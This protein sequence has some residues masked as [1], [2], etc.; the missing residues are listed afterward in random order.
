MPTRPRPLDVLFE[1]DAPQTFTDLTATL[2]PLPPA[3][4]HDVWFDEVHEQHSR[5]SVELAREVGEVVRKLQDKEQQHKHATKMDVSRIQDP[6]RNKENVGRSNR[7]RGANSVVHVKRLKPTPNRGLQIKRAN[8][9]PPSVQKDVPPASRASVALDRRRK[10]L[11][12]ARSRLNAGNQRTEPSERKEMR[13]LQE[14][15]KRHNKKFKASHT[16]EPPRHSV[17]DVKQKSGSRRT[18]RLRCGSS[19]KMR[20]DARTRTRVDVFEG[21]FIL[22]LRGGGGGCAS[23]RNWRLES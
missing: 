3:E 16:Y 22:P 5:P 17:R 8:H 10:P 13:D 18:R 20:R 23:R 9:K 4:T 6:D 15:L 19:N 1:F 11:V 14:L 12:D 21:I 7:R 2:F